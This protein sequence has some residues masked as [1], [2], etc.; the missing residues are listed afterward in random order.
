MRC[1][2]A[3]A[4]AL[5]QGNRGQRRPRGRDDHC[6]W[7]AV[8]IPWLLVAV[9][10]AAVGALSIELSGERTNLRHAR[11]ALTKSRAE[12]RREVVREWAS[13]MPRTGKLISDPY[14]PKDT[15]YILNPDMVRPPKQWGEA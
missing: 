15:L 6:Q 13:K 11:E 5:G 10:M 3:G 4:S 2:P 1:L 7:A 9:L 12:F 8:V 14:C